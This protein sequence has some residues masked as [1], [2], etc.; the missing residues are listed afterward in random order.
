MESSRF[1]SP[2]KPG[3]DD[4][5]R[6]CGRDLREVHKQL[7]Y[8]HLP[9]AGAAAVVARFQIDNVARRTAA[10]IF[11]PGPGGVLS[12][13]PRHIGAEASIKGTVRTGQDVNL[14]L[15]ILPYL[16]SVT[17]ATGSTQQ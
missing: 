13:A 9:P 8:C 6:Q 2:A 1:L 14:P 16:L 3:F 5:C 12:D 10:E 17:L 15:Q 11:G 4:T 7:F